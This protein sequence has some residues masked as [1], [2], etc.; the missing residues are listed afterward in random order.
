MKKFG[1]RFTSTL[2]WWKTWC[3]RNSERIVQRIWAILKYHKVQNQMEYSA[4]AQL[5][6]HQKLCIPKR[7]TNHRKQL[8]QFM[9]C[10]T[11]SL[12]KV[13]FVQLFKIYGSYSGDIDNKFGSQIY[14]RTGLA[15]GLMLMKVRKIGNN[16]LT[17]SI[18]SKNFLLIIK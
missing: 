10:T 5:A 7:S 9:E 17:E 11:A 2:V 1:H 3:W 15:N 14:E 18:L 4:Q 12:K 13:S 6:F 16:R 8:A